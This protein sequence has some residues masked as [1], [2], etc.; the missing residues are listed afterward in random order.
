MSYTSYCMF[1]SIYDPSN[2]HKHGVF[3][4]S[5]PLCH[6]HTLEYFL[7]VF[8]ITNLSDLAAADGITQLG[9]LITTFKW[10]IPAF[11]TFPQCLILD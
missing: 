10:W 7:E 8:H 3:N 6:L 4:L 9:D 1:Q 2:Y 11:Y 5:F